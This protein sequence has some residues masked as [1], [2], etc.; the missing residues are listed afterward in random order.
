MHRFIDG[1]RGLLHPVSASSLAVTLIIKL[2]LRLSQRLKVSESL[3]T[4]AGGEYAIAMARLPGG[5]ISHPGA[6]L[7]Y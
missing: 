6:V 5:A 7:L 3:L 2:A 4:H 1:I